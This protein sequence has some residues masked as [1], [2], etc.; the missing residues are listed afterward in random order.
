V[1]PLFAIL[2]AYAIA[3]IV[4]GVWIG[5]RVRGSDEFFVGGRA[6]GAG[7]IFA[8][9]LAPNIGAGSTVG[10]TALAYHQGM[11]AW[12]W[13]GSAGLGSLVLA[14]WIG[15]RIWREATR[16]KLLTVGDFLEHHFGRRVRALAAVIIWMGSLFILCAQLDGAAAVLTIAGGLSHTTG[17]LVG[18]LVM[19][20]YFVAGGLHA[21]ARVNG[22]QLLV[23]LGGFAIATPI[24]IAAAGG[25]GTISTLQPVGLGFWRG[26][27]ATAGWPLLFLLGP[28]FF[29]SP[30][31]L[32]KAFGA[33][34]ERSLTRGIALNGLALVGFAIVPVLLGLS[35]R[36]MYPGLAD[37]DVAL[38]VLN[39]TP[40]AV[41][42]LAL[43]A[44]FSAELSAA[45][46][47]LFM[48]STSGARDLYKGLINPDATD[49]ELL[50]AALIMAIVGGTVGFALTFVYT[51]VVSALTWFYS[52]MIVTLF[53]PILGGLF[54]PSAGRWAA[55]AAMVVGVATLLVTSLVTGGAGY[56]WVSPSFL[57]LVSSGLTYLVLAVL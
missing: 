1:T 6:L 21:A 20:A 23:K 48:L 52:L 56:G 45:D 55:F 26:S 2:I 25:W 49:R 16:L 37:A 17:C 13:N 35:A 32:Q 28:A 7:L 24:V 29:L 36:A 41:G 34:D 38:T 31:L 33:R 57:G 54:F 11:A 51:S 46:A 8:T 30:G 4:L 10:A 42:G 47:V 5:R 14:F 39:D 43:A 19:T 44:V 3:L 18:A 27:S 15:P 9:F 50:R 22:I 53:A 40:L 12:W